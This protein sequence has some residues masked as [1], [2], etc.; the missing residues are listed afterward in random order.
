MHILKLEFKKTK[1]LLFIGLYRAPNSD[2][3]LFNDLFYNLCLYLDIFI[4][5]E[6]IIDFLDIF[7]SPGSSFNHILSQLG[8]LST[9]NIPTRSTTTT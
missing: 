1:S 6:F 4:C 5:G 2:A 3:N 7:N 9:I 8:L